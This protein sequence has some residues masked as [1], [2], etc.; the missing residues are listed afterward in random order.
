[1][2]DVEVWKDASEY[3]DYFKI[4]SFGR[5]FSKRTNKILKTNVGKSGYRMFVTRF[6][7]STGKSKALKV[8]RLVAKTFIENPN[9]NT[10]VNHIDGDKTNNNVSNLE[11][12]TFS[13]NAKHSFD[14]GLS[15]ARKGEENKHSKLT[16]AI[17]DEIRNRYS[18]EKITY[19]KLAE[20]YNVGR[21]TV[22]SIIKNERYGV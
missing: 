11:W 19:N 14:V 15:R 5:V 12:T 22:R 6:S 7:G 16:N 17:A 8:H 13:G 10:V 21:T 2:K 9:D 18:T 20:I 3:E 1:M 4:S